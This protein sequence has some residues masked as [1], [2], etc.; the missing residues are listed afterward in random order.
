MDLLGSTDI[1]TGVF[2]GLLLAVAIY[3]SLFLAAPLIRPWAMAKSSRVDI[4]L[5][6]LVGMK[7]RGNPAELIVATYIIDAKRGQRHDLAMI[8]ST[9][10]AA[11]NPSQSASEL[12]AKVDREADRHSTRGTA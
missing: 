6:W 3:F 5:S 9:Y 10:M 12:L 7:L 8:E 2:V 11:P 4:P 1:R